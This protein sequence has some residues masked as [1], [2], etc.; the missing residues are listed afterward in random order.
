MAMRATDNTEE[1]Q[2]EDDYEN[3]V[4]SGYRVLPQNKHVDRLD[5]IIKVIINDHGNSYFKNKPDMDVAGQP[6]WHKLLRAEAR[7]EGQPV[8]L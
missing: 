6:C 8:K 3:V 2:R 5:L 4:T 7:K 1:N